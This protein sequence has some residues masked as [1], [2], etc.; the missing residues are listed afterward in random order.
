MAAPALAYYMDCPYPQALPFNSTLLA[1]QFQSP[2]FH[3][4]SGIQ[5]LCTG[6]RL[7]TNPSSGLHS[8]CDPALSNY[9]PVTP[10]DH[11]LPYFVFFLPSVIPP[12][13][14]Y[15]LVTL[16][17]PGFDNLNRPELQLFPKEKEHEWGNIDRKKISKLLKKISHQRAKSKVNMVGL[18]KPQKA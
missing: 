2:S 4:L 18:R 3:E 10:V 9:F 6:R 7:L 14:S 13:S 1:F 16:D 17:I 15:I 8:A 11:H 12:I 5:F